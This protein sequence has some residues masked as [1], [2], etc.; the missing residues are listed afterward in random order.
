MEYIADEECFR[1][2]HCRVLTPDGGQ[3]CCSTPAEA[4]RVAYDMNRLRAVN[5]EL[6]EALRGVLVFE[7]A[8]SDVCPPGSQVRYIGRVAADK[9]RAAIARAEE[10]I[11]KENAGS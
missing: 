4:S 6:L 3:I 2:N 9:A 10:G 1:A 5:A 11:E 7:W 8:S